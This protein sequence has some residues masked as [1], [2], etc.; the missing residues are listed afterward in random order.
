M[1][2]LL[3]PFAALALIAGLTGC[4][5]HLRNKLNLPG[6]LPQSPNTNL[7]LPPNVPALLIQSSIKYSELEKFVRR[8]LHASGVIIVDDPTATGI[9]QLKI[10]SERWGDLPTAI[11]I[12]GRAQEYSLRYAAI[13]TLIDGNGEVVVPQ[14]VIELSRDYLSPPVDATGTTTER[15]IL[16]NELRLDMSASIL[17]R[18]DSV[19]RSRLEKRELLEQAKLPSPATSGA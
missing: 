17:R 13:F 11:D 8:G 9:A 19:I 3:T 16:A 2:K 14:Q 18:I 15:E 10:L 4:D 12:Q 5:F 1:I 7:N 6:N